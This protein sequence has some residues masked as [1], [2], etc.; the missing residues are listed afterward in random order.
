MLG[1]TV[2]TITG[3]ESR[4][5]LHCEP[6]AENMVYWHFPQQHPVATGKV[7][8]DAEGKQLQDPE[9]DTCC[10]ATLQLHSPPEAKAAAAKSMP[11]SLKQGK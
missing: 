7:E 4:F 1:T 3:C 2:G 8:L 5:R 11:F 9:Q 10:A 6:V